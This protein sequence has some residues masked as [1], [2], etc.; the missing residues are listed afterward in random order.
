M[1][2]IRIHR[3]GGPEVL[4]LDDIELPPPAPDQVR[5]KHTA[6]GVNFIDTYHRS[7]L[8][9]LPM[10]AGIGSEV[11]GE[12]EAVGAGGGV[13]QASAEFRSAQPDLYT[14][15][16]RF[17]YAVQLSKPYRYRIRE[18]AQSGEEKIFPWVT[19]E[20]WT[21]ILDVTTRTP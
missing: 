3:T 12:V 15:S 18:L 5:I 7:G 20:D 17:K 11:A 6:I 1:K 21:P 16:I 4:E 8:Y 10:P 9:P 19:I 13:V 14:R 2:A